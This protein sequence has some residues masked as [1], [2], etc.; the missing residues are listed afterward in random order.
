MS[1]DQ[2]MQDQGFKNAAQKMWEAS[3]GTGDVPA[4]W[5]MMQYKAA[6][7]P[8]INNSIVA[9]KY[10]IDQAVASGAMSAEDGQLLNDFNSSG[11]TQFLTR[12][13][14]T[15]KVTI[16]YDELAKLTGTSTT[17]TTTG[18]ATVNG[19]SVTVPSGLEPYDIFE[20]DGKVYQVDS[21]GNPTSMITKDITWDDL[22]GQNL[23]DDFTQSAAYKALIKNTE[24][25]QINYKDNATTDSWSTDTPEQGE[26]FKTKVDGKDMVLKVTYKGNQDVKLGFDNAY[27][28]FEDL[29]GNKYSAGGENKNSKITAGTQSREAK[30]ATITSGSAASS[31][32]AV[33]KVAS[34]VIDP[35][36]IVGKVWNWL[37]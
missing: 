32:P 34:R 24:E 9:S 30:M 35:T 4:A 10:A 18:T 15:G 33:S 21:E 20:K 5:A 3:G 12:D 23:G 28:E 17:T 14:T 26:T 31:I 22:K 36:N 37:T 11:M 1:A 29:E 8:K 27:M 6:N 13:P 25:K 2:A 19:A 7:D 16:D